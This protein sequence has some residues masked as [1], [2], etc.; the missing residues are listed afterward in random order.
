MSACFCHV[1]E[2]ETCPTA[3]MRALTPSRLFVCGTAGLFFFIFSL[4][5][6]SGAIAETLLWTGSDGG[7]WFTDADWGPSRR[8]PGASDDVMIDTY[9]PV[10]T[11]GTSAK[12]RELLIGTAPGAGTLV[13]QGGLQTDSVFLGAVSGASGTASFI[14][15]KWQNDGDVSI[16]GS[17]VGNLS[18]LHGTTASS[19][20]VLV[21]G[22]GTGNGSLKLDNSSTLTNSDTVF[23]SGSSSGAGGGGNLEV[24]G[25]S[26]LYSARGVLAEDLGTTGTALVSGEDS[27]WTMSG[28]MVVG[29][30]GVGK[31]TVTGGGTVI[32]QTT[33]VIAN[34][35]SADG[36]SVTVSRLGSSLQSGGSLVVGNSGAA[37]L[38]VEAAGTVTSGEAI[39]GRHS[40]SEATVTGDGSNWRTGD[41]Q[42]GGDVAD[43]G[44]AAGNGKLNVL[45]GGSVDSTTARLGVV[46]GATGAAAVDGQGSVWTVN[47]GDLEVG[48]NGTGSLAVTGGGLV[49]AANIIVGTNAG[50]TG[51]A[52]V[53]GVGSK[54]QS[55]AD[56]NVGLD[57]NGSMTVEAGG[58]VESRD[59]YVAAHGGS[60]STVTV[61]GDG[62][63]WA[64]TGTFF[65]GYGGGATGNV[66]VSAG[67]GIKAAKVMLG[68][69]A[70]SSGT[71]TITGAGSNVTAYIDNGVVNSGSVDVGFE[72]SGSLTVTNGGSLDA[73][74]LY[75]G[76]AAGSNGNVLVSGVGSRV[77]VGNLMVVGDAGN[78][79]V[80]ITGGASLAAPTILIAASA[81][82]T[83]VLNIGAAAGQTARSAGALEARTI[84]FGAGNGS[85]VFN[86]SETGYILSADISGAGKVVA[87]AGV[88]TLG[89]NNSYSGGTTIS[90][91][92]L[93]GTSKSFGSG[94]I[95]NDAQLVVDGAGTLS[96]GI[97]GTGTFEK[98]GDGNLVL[99]GNST[100]TGTT[101]VSSGKLSVNGSLASPVSVGTGA[102][103][104]GS[105]TIGGLTVGSGGTLAPGNSIG[106]LASTG[107]ATFA[108]GS[109]YE[110]EIDAAGNSDRLAVTGTITIDN[111]VSLVVTSLA[112]Q[113]A[114]SLSTRYTIL[115]ATGGITGTFSSVG[116][117]FAYLTARVA[118]SADDG[119]TYLSFARASPDAGFLAA[120]TSTANARGAA[121]AIEALGE[122][123]PLYEAAV[124][125]QQG[126]TQSAF[127]Q[128]AGEIHPSLAMALI[129][130]SQL[131]RDVILNRLRSA[132]EGVDARPILPVAY[133]EGGS[134][135]F[136]IDEGSL[137]FWSS[138]FGSRGR[139]DGDG[140]GA[141]AD[142]K[143]GGVLFG[144]DG[145]LADG[146]RAGVAAG[147]GR[148]VISQGSPAASADV[149]S[150]YVAGY[151]GKTIGPAS[152]RLG[153]THAF[154]DVETRRAVSFSTLKE[155]LT[156]GYDAS[157]TQVFAEAAWR[158]DF[159]LTHIEPYANIAYVNTRTDAFREMGG[160][161]AVSSGA[162]SH[163]E[164][165]STLGARI[166]RDIALEGMLGRAMLDIGWRHAYGDPMMESALF[167]DGGSA[168]SVTSAAMAR[169]VALINLGL[170]Y[171]LNPSATLTFRYGA[172]FGAGLLDQSASA[173]LGVRF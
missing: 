140:N 131:T 53:S 133:A 12:A 166:S 137:T 46:A 76:S 54:L 15:A 69:L 7:D 90:S 3:E 25:A 144:V 14:G 43:P 91:G 56:L 108:S 78:G 162:V 152:L 107:S 128:L 153:A 114:Y 21:G 150:Y 27:H 23:V 75:A 79:S 97:S 157:T 115:T 139:I 106:T 159:D 51:S 145:D 11:I 171:N 61:A 44:G 59:G 105:G 77:A 118:R 125:L 170:S 20:N 18:L 47:R 82:S 32:S 136:D 33:T 163:D 67:G 102:T 26:E 134:N 123:S 130:R 143:G 160:I 45:A 6:T 40:A 164:F 68:N 149:D 161:A 71:M 8:V 167:Y 49:D 58:T 72:G 112:N 173:Q 124:F 104:G 151:A 52:R 39:V 57:G 127:A 96:N 158:F 22:S 165:Y 121:N 42:V 16:G 100:Y 103:L 80:E 172:V 30:A 110:V 13:V 31:L 24:L 86:H 83:G 60:T 154:Q 120:E 109:R 63:S 94:G 119:T 81:G 87:E 168:F 116:E 148:D 129:N 10:I 41:L 95:A 84:A 101:A 5:A 111:D 85:I 2:G 138:G 122:S 48:V 113:T 50:G 155:Y 4:A 28:D 1:S 29:E 98:T 147:Y 37:T 64:M 9:G 126:E 66:S 141:S 93:K 142:M 156:A 117:N 38:L 19:K 99:T 135:P 132:F 62:S 73:Y 34:L 65:V 35:A 169:D 17:G 146:W 89:G 55:R 88:T 36:S 92:T 74:D 70:G